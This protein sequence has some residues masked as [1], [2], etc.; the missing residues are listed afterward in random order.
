MESR[1]LGDGV[2]ASIKNGMIMLSTGSHIEDDAEHVIWLEPEVAIELKKYIEQTMAE[3][4]WKS[5]AY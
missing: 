4:K 3:Y 2:Y 5:P 1:Y